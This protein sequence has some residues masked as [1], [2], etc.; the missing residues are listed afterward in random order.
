[1]LNSEV[2]TG[3][4]MNIAEMCIVESERLS[5]RSLTTLHYYSLETV[6]P[7]FGFNN[8]GAYRALSHGSCSEGPSNLTYAQC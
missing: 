4:R 2:A 8:S 3:R 6:I 7:F 1:M 5:A